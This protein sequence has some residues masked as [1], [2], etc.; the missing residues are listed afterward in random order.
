MSDALQTAIDRAWEERTTISP[1][2]R[3]ETREAVF[4]ALDLLDAGKRRVAE[5]GE[6][7]WTSTNG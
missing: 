1:E 6:N 7:G 5:P 4:E 2:T 3:G